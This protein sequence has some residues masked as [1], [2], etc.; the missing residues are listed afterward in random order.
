MHVHHTA[1]DWE[2]Y[3]LLF[4]LHGV[5]TVRDTGYADTT[6]LAKRQQIRE[7]K[8]VGPRLFACGPI[9]DG[10]PPWPF[11]WF[12]VV[13]TPAEARAAVDEIAQAGV[14]CVKPYWGLSA[15][16]LAA[17]R[18][19]ATQHE[20]PVVGHIP[21]AVPFEAA[22]IGD[23]QHLTGVPV[24]PTYVA[25]TTAERTAQYVAFVAA[26]RDLE[27]ARIGFIVRTSV[28]QGLAHTPTLVVNARF[29][30][31]RD[32]PT[33]LAD[34]VAQLLPRWYRAV[35]WK[36]RAVF[37]PTFY[38]NLGAAF[39]KMKDVVHPRQTRFNPWIKKGLGGPGL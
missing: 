38:E 37:A 33:L 12:R 30:Q 2:L 35:L 13:R 20:L 29:A 25:T 17:I 32:Y 31:L 18:E 19:A 3:G 27:A 24:T 34:P 23:V 36:P 15:E 22:H 21:F 11:S 4:L 39:P 26:W 16:T 7:G 14:D 6:I 10:N 8:L 9:L 5:T 28:E 1:I